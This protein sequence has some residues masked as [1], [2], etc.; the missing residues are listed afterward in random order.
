MKVLLDE[1][2]PKKLKHEVQADFV[3]TVPE[4]GWAGTKDGPLLRL[5]EREFDVFLT[6]DQSLEHQQ[7]LEQFDLAVI[8]LV[9]QTNDIEDLKPRMPTVNDLIKSI[10]SIKTAGIARLISARLDKLE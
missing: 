7:K 4:M 3:K 9:A 2:L 6:I 1:C 8:L 10:D 5:A